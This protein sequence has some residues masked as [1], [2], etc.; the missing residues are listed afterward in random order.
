MKYLERYAFEF[1]P[2]I[3]KIPD[4]PDLITDDTVSDYFKFTYEERLAIKN[5]TKRKYLIN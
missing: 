4:F 1:I 2:D 5:I 3:T